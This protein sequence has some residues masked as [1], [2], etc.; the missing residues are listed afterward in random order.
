V[1]ESLRW[2]VICRESTTRRTPR[3]KI[4]PHNKWNVS[5]EFKVAVIVAGM[6]YLCFHDL[7]HR[8]ANA[9]IN[10]KVNRYTAGAALGHKSAASTKRCAHLAT[11]AMKMALG[12]IGKKSPHKRKARVA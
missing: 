12:K 6:E 2:S 3:R 9:M 10:A 5:K 8:P 11:D 4:S 7:R 1:S